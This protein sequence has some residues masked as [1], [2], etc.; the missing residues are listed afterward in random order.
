MRS[1]T[2]GKASVAKYHGARRKQNREAWYEFH[3]SQAEAIERTAVQLA[4]D[5][6]GRAEALAEKP[7]L[8]G[9][10]LMTLCKVGYPLHDAASCSYPLHDA[11]S[12]NQ[13]SP[14]QCEDPHAI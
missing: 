3:L 1:T 6:R 8:P 2:F 7:K 14:M 5:Y 10:W 9:A 11:A 4:T 12:C 13:E